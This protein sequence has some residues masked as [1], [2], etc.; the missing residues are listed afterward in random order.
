MKWHIMKV[1]VIKLVS[2][3]QLSKLHTVFNDRKS[4]I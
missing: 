4:C 2:Y 1:T 3:E